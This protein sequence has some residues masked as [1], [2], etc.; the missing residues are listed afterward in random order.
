MV[1]FLPFLVELVL[2]VYC[3][4]DCIQSDE[5][6]IRNLR[7]GWWILL[8]IFFPL[9]GG[10]AWLVAGRPQRGQGRRSVAWPSTQTSGFPEYE[11]PRRALAPDDDPQ[12]LE[13]M[14]RGN[15]EQEQLLKKWEDD[16]RRREEQLRE[17][18]TDPEGS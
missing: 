17:K 16:L 18:P 13:E 12:F 10:I 6:E 11:R 9:L 2:L 5:S 15:A 8:I 7:K 1:R 3:L 14:R 4:I